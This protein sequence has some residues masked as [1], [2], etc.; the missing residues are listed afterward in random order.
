MTRITRVPDDQ[1]TFDGFDEFAAE[2][3][4]PFRLDDETCRIG[5][6][7]IAE[8]RRILDGFAERAA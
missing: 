7:R 6:E 4:T 3:S 2:Q 8:M 5:L 1:M